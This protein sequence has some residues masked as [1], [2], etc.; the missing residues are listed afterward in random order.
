MNKMVERIFITFGISFIVFSFVIYHITSFEVQFGMFW[1]ILLFCWD[2]FWFSGTGIYLI[3]VG[4]VI[5]KE[6]IGQIKKI[7]MGGYFIIFNLVFFVFTFLF[8]HLV[9]QAFQSNG[10]I[11][12]YCLQS[13][14]RLLRPS[15]SPDFIV[16]FANI[17][18]FLALSFLFKQ[19]LEKK[20]PKG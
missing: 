3:V 7:K 15:F 8:N 11:F 19:E 12:T 10:R 5:Q 16:P 14:P 6:N 13:I 2:I 1:N 20:K 4:I 17:V 9:E 18:I